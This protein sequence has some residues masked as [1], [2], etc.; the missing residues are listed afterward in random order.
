MAAAV[1]LQPEPLSE[2][3]VAVLGTVEV[4]FPYLE[5]QAHLKTTMKP[6]MTANIW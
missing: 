1:L 3:V 5:K 2:Q 4:E 6:T